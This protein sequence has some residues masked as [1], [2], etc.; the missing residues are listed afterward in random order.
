[1]DGVICCLHYPHFIIYKL[2]LTY[3]PKDV[4]VGPKNIYLGAEIHKFQFRSGKS[5]LSML[6]TQYVKK[7]NPYG[8][9]TVEGLG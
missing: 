2:G 1:M 7:F 6:S 9:R 4:L 8:R 5:H 3:D